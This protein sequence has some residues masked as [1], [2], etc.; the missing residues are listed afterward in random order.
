MIPANP[1]DFAGKAVPVTGGGV[2]IG[3]GIAEAFAAADAEGCTMI[4]DSRNH[5]LASTGPDI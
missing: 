4:G 2:G 1:L 3:R 5:P